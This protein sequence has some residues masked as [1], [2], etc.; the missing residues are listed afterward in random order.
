MHR[1]KASY[2]IE[3]LMHLVFWVGA[4][5]ALKGLAASSFLILVNNNGAIASQDGRLLFPYA[6]VVLVF[7]ILLF[8][9]N[10]FWLFRNISRHTVLLKRIAILVGWLLLLYSLDYLTVYLLAASTATNVL[11]LHAIMP[12]VPP[13]QVHTI[14]PPLPPVHLSAFTRDNWLAMQP[15]IA[16]IFI[17]VSGLASAYFYVGESINKELRRIQA[18]AYQANTEL[19]FLRSQVNPHFLFNTLN[20][21]FSLAQGEG[22]DNVADKIGKLSGMMRY[23]IYDSITERVPLEKEISYLKDCIAL[24]QMRYMDSQVDV[25][26][27]YPDD[28]AIAP[29]QLAPM[30]LISFVENAFKH[31]VYAR[32]HS[33]ITIGITIDQ[34]SLTFICENTDHSD[35]KRAELEK[36]G[37]GLEN[38]RRRLDLLYPGKH[39]LKLE[40]ENGKYKVNL[41]IDFA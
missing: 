41:E 10:S 19:K 35:I 8:Y 14:M 20:N 29:V 12:P 22:K 27:S 5:Y 34:K 1:T 3:F 6:W 2:L 11:Q 7:M 16:L 13:V 23:M 36:G 24:H 26:F 25:S 9:S 18:E 32:R 21:L 17:L 37:I 40:S 33:Y 30:L 4:Y 31:G 38:V 39:K 15:I 28:V